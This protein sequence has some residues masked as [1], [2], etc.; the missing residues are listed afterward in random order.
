MDAVTSHWIRIFSVKDFD[1]GPVLGKGAFGTVY[2]ARERSSEFIV[3]LKVLSKSQ[4][5][6]NRLEYQLRREIEIQGRLQH[7]NILRLY[8]YFHDEHKVFLIL[9]YA[10]RGELHKELQRYQ[11]FD[12]TRTATI[13]EEMADALLYCHERNVIHRDIKPENLLMGLQGEMK[14]AD[15]GCSVHSPSLRRRTLC[16]TLDYMSPEIATHQAYSEKVDLWSLGVLCF[17]LLVG[18]PP[19]TGGNTESDPDTTKV[20]LRF[21]RTVPQGARDL[22]SRL[23]RHNPEQRLP[24]REV[25]Q[26]PWVRAHSCRVLPPGYAAAP[27]R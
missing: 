5:E 21:P 26:H 19:F 23:L 8:N 14:I 9:E 25:L 4:L 6:K 11:R 18:H 20:G 24:L 10:P 3:A 22:I 1:V 16:G 15:F 2:L 13:M 7:P 12:A 17:E 27:A